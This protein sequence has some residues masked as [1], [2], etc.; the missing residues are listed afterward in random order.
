[1]KAIQRVSTLMIV[2]PVLWG[3]VGHADFDCKGKAKGNYA[4]PD[5]CHNY[6]VC[7][8]DQKRTMP[9]PK[10]LVFNP[11]VG[12][13]KHEGK[14]VPAAEYACEPGKSTPESKAK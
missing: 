3:G 4:N 2:L 9:C 11:K 5:D 1:M 14:C 6:I 13:E 12:E 10:G 7:V 8:G